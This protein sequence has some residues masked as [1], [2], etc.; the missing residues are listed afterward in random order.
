M[1]P[2]PAEQSDT[3]ELLTM[4]KAMSPPQRA[5]LLR[6]GRTIKNTTGFAPS[7]E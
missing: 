2:A 5:L 7:N 1:G 4:W 3:A 6:I